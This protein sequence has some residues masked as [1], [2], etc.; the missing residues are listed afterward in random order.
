[1]RVALGAAMSAVIHACQT[2]GQPLLTGAA[3]VVGGCWLDCH[4]AKQ[5]NA[6]QCPCFKDRG[7]CV[8]NSYGKSNIVGGE[9][10]AGPAV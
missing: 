3:S 8:R 4:L 6:G 2:D 5:A 10:G 7:L 1:M 9:R